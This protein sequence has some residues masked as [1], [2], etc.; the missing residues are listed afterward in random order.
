MLNASNY[1]ATETLPNGLR[2]LIRATEPHDDLAG[3]V[4]R[5][6][7]PTSF[8]YRFLRPK[9]YLTDEEIASLKNCDFVSQVA[10]IGLVRHNLRM[11][12]V[13]G[14]RYWI[15]RPDEAEITFMVADD[16]QKQGIGTAMTFNGHSFDLPVLR[17]RA[18]VKR[19]SGAG[20]R[21]R[22]YFHRYTDDALD[23]CDVLGS[24]V[25]GSKVK[26]DEVSK[27]PGLTGKPDG[28]DGSRVEEMVHAGQIEEVARYCESD[29][30]NT[31]CSAA[32]RP[33]ALRER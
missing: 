16:Y 12:I 2:L 9:H 22:Q 33:V 28:I 5:K 10:L 21:V 24:Y 18:L 3:A 32:S 31:P 13:A 25:P 17:Y 14:A 7:S 19:I 27:I 29:V 6:A 4:Q 30:L 23:L 20:L 8:F 26:L 1:L 15:T 11:A